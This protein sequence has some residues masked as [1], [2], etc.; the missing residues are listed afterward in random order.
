MN[1]M[2]DLDIM[3]FNFALWTP[4]M[5]EKKTYYGYM[6]TCA[7]FM[8]IHRAQAVPRKLIRKQEHF[9]VISQAS[10]SFWT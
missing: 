10:T 1:L 8:H 4:S 7:Y 9:F 6:N 2:I 3:A 5:T